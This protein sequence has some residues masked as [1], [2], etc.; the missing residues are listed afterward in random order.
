VNLSVQVQPSA[1]HPILCRPAHGVFICEWCVAQA[2]EL[3][4]GAASR[5]RRRGRCGWTVG[6]EVWWSFWGEEARQGVLLV[7]SGLAGRL[8]GKF[9]QGARIGDECLDLCGE[10]LAETSI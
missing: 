7:A 9:G 10:I 5:T 3:V 4:A 1:C 8:A 2:S 6:L